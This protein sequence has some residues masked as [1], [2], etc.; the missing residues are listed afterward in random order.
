[1][2]RDHHQWPVRFDIYMRRVWQGL[3]LPIPKQ[4]MSFVAIA[5]RPAR[6]MAI[7][8]N[9][10]AMV[11]LKERLRFGPAGGCGPSAL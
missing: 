6:V 7:G 5:I 8:L 9:I 4:Y 2:G 10:D 1:V 3:W 11:V